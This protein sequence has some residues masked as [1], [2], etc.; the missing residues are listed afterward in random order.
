MEAVEATERLLRLSYCGSQ[1][2][3]GLRADSS[4]SKEPVAAAGREMKDVLQH[5]FAARPDFIA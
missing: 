5:H 2:S 1:S 3:V 4:F